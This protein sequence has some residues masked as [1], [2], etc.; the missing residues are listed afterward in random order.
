MSYL[1]SRRDSLNKHPSFFSVSEMRQK[2]QELRE[3]MERAG[4]VEV[5]LCGSLD[6]DP[7]GPEAQ[8]LIAIARKP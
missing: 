7:Y 4:F 8:R 6:G 3:K 5:R 2:G 1:M